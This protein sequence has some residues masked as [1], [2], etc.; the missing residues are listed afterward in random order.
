MIK[1]LLTGITGQDGSYLVELPSLDH[2][3]AKENLGGKLG[4]TF[5]D[6][7]GTMDV[8]IRAAGLE[9]MCGGDK[10]LV[11]RSPNRWGGVN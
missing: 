9:S 5:S 11:E 6:P 4:I 7:V 1:A 8:D 10:T 2:A 3:K